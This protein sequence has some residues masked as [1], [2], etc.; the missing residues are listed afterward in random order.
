MRRNLYFR[1]CFYFCLFMNITI[2]HPSKTD[3]YNEDTSNIPE[4]LKTLSDTEGLT[5]RCVRKPDATSEYLIKNY[6]SIDGFILNKKS[7]SNT[8]KKL[9][10]LPNVGIRYLEINESNINDNGLKYISAFKHLISLTI[11]KI[12]ITGE[13]LNHLKDNKNIAI[14]DFN[15]CTLPNN[16]YEIIN[17]LTGLTTLYINC[18]KFQNNNL[19]FNIERLSS[20]KSLY[21]I[22]VP[23]DVNQLKRIKSPNLE[24]IEITNLEDNGLKELQRFNKLDYLDISKSRITNK[25]LPYLKNMNILKLLLMENLKNTIDVN[26]LNRS[27]PKNIESLFVKGTLHETD[28]AV[29]KKSHPNLKVF[30]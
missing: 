6:Q 19:T 4:V 28:I 16:F 9:A 25:G 23:I 11:E 13:N 18:P 3:A 1:R 26:E 29:L 22:D 5:F 15:Q 21:L 7:D 8:L 27:L 2:I 14:I 30:P 20:L 12:N 24:S 10:A 17:S